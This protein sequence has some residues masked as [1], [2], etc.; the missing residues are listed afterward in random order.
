M[1]PCR[2]SDQFLNAEACAKSGTGLA[3]EPGE[4]SVESIRAAVKRSL[5]EDVFRQAAR[6]VSAD[7]SA[8]PSPADVAEILAR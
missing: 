6:R 1:V 7:I 5:T 4:A 2:A 8:M 3:L